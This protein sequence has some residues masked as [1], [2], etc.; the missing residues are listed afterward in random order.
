MDAPRESVVPEARFQQTESSIP[1][2]FH[3]PSPEPR[4]DPAIR[5]VEPAPDT[6]TF[7]EV[8]TTPLPTVDEPG[9][10]PSS[11]EAARDAVYLAGTSFA[12]AAVRGVAEANTLEEVV[13]DL[14]NL[15]PSQR[16]VMS[17][18]LTARGVPFRWEGASLVA[19]TSDA[20]TIND[21]IA[22]LQG[23][24]SDPAFAAASAEPLVGAEP[25]DDEEVPAAPV[26]LGDETV[27]D[28]LNLSSEERRHLSMRLTGA[29]IAHRWQVGTDLIVS[30]ADADRIDSY[31]Q[32]VQNPDGFAD[33]ELESF[34]EDVDD[35]A[36]YAA[37][38]NLYVAADRLMQR[39][40]DASARTAFYDAS[41]DVEGLPAPFGFDPRV[42]AQVLGLA[43][44][45]AGG[46][47]AEVNED[48]I[49]ADARTLRQLLV[50]YV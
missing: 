3:D 30:T 28:L 37:M 48:A 29:G 15:A 19:P 6:A 17:M 4:P 27:F 49:A 20:A 40:N 35:E 5:Y 1:T 14:T 2:R 7:N 45:I 25:S 11:I 36:V 47:D 34:D 31:V 18:R 22:D 39:A 23:A 26:A 41:D 38:S 12:D 24:A 44:S 46:M 21:A 43:A 13:F 9:S 50:N 16:Q 10:G 32:E 8:H 42:W 33:D